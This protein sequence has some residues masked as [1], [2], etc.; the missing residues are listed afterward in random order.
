MLQPAWQSLTRRRLS[1]STRV[2]SALAFGPGDTLKISLTT[3][4]DQTPRRPHQ[5]FLTLQDPATGAEDAYPI[6]IKDAG[7][8]K[9]ELVRIDTGTF[10][11]SLANF[12]A[13]LTRTFLPSS[14]LH[15]ICS[16]RTSY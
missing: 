13:R 8:G 6:N 3:V 9:L 15:P 7:K 14:L 10:Y 1:P 2:Q 11:N 4:D 5:A 12:D 16:T